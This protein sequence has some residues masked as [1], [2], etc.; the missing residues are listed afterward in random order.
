MKS[1]TYRTQARR[2]TPHPQAFRSKVER[3][4]Q[5]GRGVKHIA[6]TATKLRRLL[7]RCFLYCQATTSSN[8]E[9]STAGGDADSQQDVS[10]AQREV[11]LQRVALVGFLRRLLDRYAKGED[12]TWAETLLPKAADEE[13]AAVTVSMQV[14]EEEAK[15]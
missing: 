13:L 12:H 14:L 10:I 2:I 9:P 6:P 15:G 4:I 7:H 5:D 8:A 11:Q 3:N 1:E